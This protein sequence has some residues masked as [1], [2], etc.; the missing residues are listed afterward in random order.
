VLFYE[1][2]SVKF[3]SQLKTNS[4]ILRV[5]LRSSVILMAILTISTVGAFANLGENSIRIDNPV[6][7]LTAKSPFK[8]RAISLRPNISFRGNQ[9]INVNQPDRFISLNTVITYQ[10]GNATFVM[11]VK[12]KVLLNGKVTFNPN[13]ATR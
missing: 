8:S 2:F 6:K 13:A 10:K 11:P 7:S 4:S 1:F 9:V 5:A 12:K 3:A